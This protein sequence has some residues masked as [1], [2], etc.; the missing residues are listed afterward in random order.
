M[1][2]L[3]IILVTD[4]N[5]WIDLLHGDIL[6]EV[7]HLPYQFCTSDFARQEFRSIHPD[8]L[9]D[10]GLQFQELAGEYVLEITRIQQIRPRLSI[11]D[12]AALILARNLGAILIT[13]DRGLNLFASDQGLTVHGVLWLLDEMVASS[14]IS[15]EK[16]VRSLEQMRI[17]GAR[18]PDEECERRFRD[19]SAE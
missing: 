9:E 7:F 2:S 18:L 14:T 10:W 4:T 15:R 16:A 17:H 3:K 6:E 13:G 8:Q 1:P 5:I 19:W 11:P 12:V